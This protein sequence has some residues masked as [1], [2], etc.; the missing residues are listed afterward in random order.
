[1]SEANETAKMGRT[2]TA[3]PTYEGVDILS[4]FEERADLIRSSARVSNVLASWFRKS[5]QKTTNWGILSTGEVRMSVPAAAPTRKLGLPE[6]HFSSVAAAFIP[7]LIMLLAFRG[8]VRSA[9]S[10]GG[11][12]ASGAVQGR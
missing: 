11:S 7:G 5:P 12:A 4:I 6:D 8:P 3:E 1:M 10:S 9:A 2:G